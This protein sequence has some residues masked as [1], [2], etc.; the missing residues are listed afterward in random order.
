MLSFTNSSGDFLEDF[1]IFCLG[2]G[3][4][5]DLAVDVG[6]EDFSDRHV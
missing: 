3:Y 2:E 5:A 4:V 6:D 1:F